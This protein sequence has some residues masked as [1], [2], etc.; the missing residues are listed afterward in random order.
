MFYSALLKYAIKGASR[1]MPNDIDIVEQ[2][3]ML[4]TRLVKSLRNFSY[5]RWLKTID[6]LS[7]FHR[8]LQVDLVW[9]LTDFMEVMPH[10]DKNKF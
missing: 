8:H 2:L 10:I 5:E 4:V 9:L 1:F 7:L 3:A 6:R